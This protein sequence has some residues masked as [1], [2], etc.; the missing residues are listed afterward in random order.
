MSFLSLISASCA[1]LPFEV[2]STENFE[3]YTFFF[4]WDLT[5]VL[6][7][8]PLFDVGCI[9]FQREFPNF[10]VKYGAVGS[11]I[12]V[13]DLVLDDISILD[14]RV[15][16]DL[17]EREVELLSDYPSF[18]DIRLERLPSRYSAF[19]D[20]IEDLSLNVT[21]LLHPSLLNC[22]SKNTQLEILNTASTAAWSELVMV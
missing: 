4:A 8:T 20:E 18:H 1:G 6:E 11:L 15:Y 7:T 13:E 3:K 9:Y 22:F 21:D 19:L 10:T 12:E 2:E 14:N 16:F 17:S 5:F